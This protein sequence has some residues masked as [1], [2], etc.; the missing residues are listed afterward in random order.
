MISNLLAPTMFRTGLPLVSNI[1]AVYL[2]GII[3]TVIIA[4]LQQR[5]CDKVDILKY[6]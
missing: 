6:G 2:D 5:I 4:E 1:S 3:M